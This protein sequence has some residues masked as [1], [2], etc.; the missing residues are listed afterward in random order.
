MSGCWSQIWHFVSR[1]QWF[2]FGGKLK[3]IYF[4]VVLCRLTFGRLFFEMGFFPFADFGLARVFCK[5]LTSKLSQ[6]SQLSNFVRNS[7]QNEQKKK[8]KK[9]M[10]KE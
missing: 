5:C 2:L 1:I 6:H 8:K 10:E 3:N 9:K 4:F 7:K